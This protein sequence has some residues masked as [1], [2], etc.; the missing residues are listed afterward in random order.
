[1]NCIWNSY[2]KRIWDASLLDS[3]FTAFTSP[4][5]NRCL[6]K[7]GFSVPVPLCVSCS[8]RTF[9]YWGWLLIR[10]ATKTWEMVLIKR[11]CEGSR[12]EQRRG[13]V[14]IH[15]LKGQRGASLAVQGWGVCLPR[16]LAWL[17][18]WPRNTPR[19][20]G[21]LNPCAAAAEAH[22]PR[23]HALHQEKPRKEKPAH[24]KEEQLPTS[25]LR[26]RN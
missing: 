20:S 17:R 1:M 3:R 5:K 11:V 18:P 6:Q 2:P 7:L 26:H 10:G 21:Q 8:R 14:Y 23:A 25:P 9:T 4:P 12:E 15:A 24:G 19:A 13:L 16:Q 22:A